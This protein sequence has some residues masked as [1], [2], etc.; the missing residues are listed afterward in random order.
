MEQDLKKEVQKIID[1]SF[2]LKDFSCYKLE[3]EAF[4]QARDVGLH[5]FVECLTEAPLDCPFSIR[6]EALSYCKCP[7]RVYI[8]KEL[9]K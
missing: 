2:C 6:L 7:L 9:G 4:C 5:S 8:C 1:H 3:F